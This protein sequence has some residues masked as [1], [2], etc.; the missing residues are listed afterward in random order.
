MA[1]PPVG[2]Y[3][4]DRRLPSLPIAE[5]AVGVDPINRAWHPQAIAVLVSPP[6]SPEPRT[7]VATA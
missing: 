5:D 4:A 2:E 7:L 6:I 1:T 3:L